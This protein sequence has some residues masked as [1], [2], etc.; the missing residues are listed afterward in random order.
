MLS[1][2]K[3]NSYD[4]KIINLIFISKSIK[5]REAFLFFRADNMNIKIKTFRNVSRLHLKPFHKNHY[6]FFTYSRG[7]R[8]NVTGEFV[9]CCLLDTSEHL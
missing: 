7:V 1:I 4:A 9:L 8:E 2:E 3:G 5:A 6:K